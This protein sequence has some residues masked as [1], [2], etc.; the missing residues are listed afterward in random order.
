MTHVIELEIK[1]FYTVYVEDEDGNMTEEGMIQ[2]AKRQA[3]DD[4]NNLTLTD[5]MEIEMDD[6]VWAE[7][8]YD[9]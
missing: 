2:E 5:G 4:E 8:Q 1:R 6:I 7:Y 3:V 9:I